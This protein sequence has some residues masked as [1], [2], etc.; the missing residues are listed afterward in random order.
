MKNDFALRVL[1]LMS[2]DIKKTLNEQNNNLR[3]APTYGSSLTNVPNY[4]NQ[5]INKKSEKDN[6]LR[7][8][9]TYG[10]ASTVVL[11]D[12]NWKGDRKSDILYGLSDPHVMIPILSVAVG[13]VTGGIGSLVLSGLLELTDVALYI[14]EDDYETAGISLIFSLLPFGVVVSR[15]TTKL[16]KYLVSKI[17]KS[18][19][20]NLL[21]KIKNKVKLNPFEKKVTDAINDQKSLF[22]SDILKTAGK[23]GVKKL[24]NQYTGRKLLIFILY[25]IKYGYISSKAGIKLS[26]FGG[27]FVTFLQLGKLLGLEIE[28]FYSGKVEVPEKL[29]SV[30]KEVIEKE[31]LSK[32]TEIKTQTE[33]TMTK[34]IEMSD[35]KKNEEINKSLYLLEE[36]LKKI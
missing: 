3:S 22:M 14:S 24:I 33:K 30:K 26:I 32:E 16:G 27:V 13:L 29:K 5:E 9:P 36:D 8:I 11:D 18:F 19:V 21:K 15:L 6:N 35:D 2:Y 17:D 25:L 10:S 20:L 7:A 34:L 4:V 31:L 23:V 1:F 28:N 12:P